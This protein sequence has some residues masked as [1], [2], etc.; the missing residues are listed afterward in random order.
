MMVE[1][2]IHIRKIDMEIYLI[3]MQ[4][5]KRI[6]S[7]VRDPNLSDIDKRN[8]VNELIADFLKR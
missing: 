1:Y 4:L 5:V 8:V 3:N 7:D 6:S 2:L